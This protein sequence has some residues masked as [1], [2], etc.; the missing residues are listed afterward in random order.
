MRILFY[1]GKGGVGKTSVAAAT[2]CALAAQGKRVLV[3]S[4]DQAHSLG[5]AFGV[6]L[7]GG[8]LQIQENLYAEEID[9]VSESEKAWGKLQGYL[10][11]LLISH[12]QNGL[13]AEELLVFPG[14]EELF[15]LFKILDYYEGRG[16]PG[17]EGDLAGEAPPEYQR[18]GL[19]G[20]GGA[21]L[22]VLVVDCAP[23]GETLSLLKFPEQFGNLM[24]TFLPVERKVVKVAGPAV[25][26]IA[27]LPMPK[28]DVFEELTLLVEK[29]ERL[30]RLMNDQSVVSL[31]I[32]TTPE[33]IVIR[34]A[35]HNFTCL[36]LYGYQVDAVIVNRIY[37]RHALEGYFQA[38]IARQEENMQE[39]R[40]SFGGIPLFTLELQDHELQGIEALERAAGLLY[41]EKDPMDIFFAGRIMK[42]EKQGEK[43]VLKLSLPFAEKEETVLEASG[44]ELIVTVRNEK[45]RFML[46]DT[47]KGKEVSGAAFRDG[48][49]EVRF[50]L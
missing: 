24:R 41:G 20:R 19:P 10:K 49:L 36:H 43:N 48:W 2:A 30:Q 25:E 42:I 32:V 13:E 6:E 50:S 40:E 3:M 46:P 29:L 18:D 39:L 26:K 27:K 45:R 21:A 5:D 34:E 12:A 23:T 11:E 47:L 4:T 35:K 38:W 14:L 1:T 31:R 33:K 7:S 28:D 8:P 22:D 9:V 44:S 15:S 16:L 17:R 37:P